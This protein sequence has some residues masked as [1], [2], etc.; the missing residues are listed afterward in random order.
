MYEYFVKYNLLTE[1]QYGFSK[2]HS[3][4]YV[5]V[6]LIDHISKEMENGKIPTNVCIDLT[7]A[8]DTL[9]FDVL[10]FKLKYYGVTDTA[11]NLMRSYLTNR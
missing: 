2:Q 6:N 1:Q 4:E 9:T 10:L 8:F 11:L 7:K 3:T 5:S